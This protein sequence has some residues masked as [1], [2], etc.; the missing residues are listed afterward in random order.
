MG[1][2]QALRKLSPEVVRELR[3]HVSPRPL[4]SPFAAS[5]AP[6]AKN[7]SLQKV[8]YGCIALTATAAS[9]P[10]VA[11]WWVG[12]GLVEK[13]DPLTTAQNR[14]GAF[15]NSGSRDV[16]KD[17]NWDFR[18]GVYTG[19]LSGYAAISEDG[20]VKSLPPQYLALPTSETKSH[21]Q[22]L[23]DFAKGKRKIDGRP[24]ER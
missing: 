22:N 11:Y 6:P 18:N 4:P 24:I 16:G 19:Q 8:L 14:R 9:F 7:S 23:E 17:P 3:R 5:A 1:G 21:E 12:D 15:L 20:K 10:L 2:S 13:D